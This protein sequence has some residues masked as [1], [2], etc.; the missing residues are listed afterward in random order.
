MAIDEVFKYLERWYGVQIES[1]DNFRSG[2]KLSFKVKSESLRELLSII[3]R[4]T[5]IQYTIDGQKVK[6]AIK[7]E[8]SPNLF[9]TSSSVSKLREAKIRTP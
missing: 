2:Q 9:E 8:Q 5:P 3:N 6:I 4:I 1:A 7:R